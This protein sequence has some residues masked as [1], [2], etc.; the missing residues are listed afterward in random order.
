MD[1]TETRESGERERECRE[2]ECRERVCR[3]RASERASGVRELVSEMRE[4][5]VVG[6]SN[7]LTNSYTPSQNAFITQPTD[8]ELGKPAD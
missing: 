3:E 6:K 7:I 2:R 1:A 5:S 8:M 4:E